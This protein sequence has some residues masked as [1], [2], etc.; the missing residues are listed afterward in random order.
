[1]SAAGAELRYPR[2]GVAG[3]LGRVAGR[4]T[5]L[6]RALLASRL[7]VL[8][9]GIAGALTVPRRLDWQ[10]FDPTHLTMRLGA[11]GNVLAAPAIRWDSVHYLAIAQHGYTRP[12]EAVFFPLYPLLI[13]VLGL[14]VGSDA[15][16]GVVISV[17]SSAAAFTML[18][19]LTELELGRRAADGAVLLL[20]FAP[21]SF[22]FT[23]VYTESLFL[24]LSLGSFYAA[25]RERWR[26]AAVLA[27]M[28]AVTR[29]TGVVL[30]IPLAIMRLRQTRRFE[31]GLAWVLL[32]PA[33]LAGYLAF[34]A[35]KGFGALAPVTEQTGA[36]H[37]HLL[38]GPIDTIVLAVRWAF[39]GVQSLATVAPYQPSLSGPF[40][41]GAENIM[42]LAVLA[43]GVAALVVA[44]RRLPLAYGAYAATALLVCISSP[45]AGLPLHSL[46]RYALTIFPLWM[47]AGAWMAKHRLARAV[48]L[49]G[50]ALLAFFTF[51]FA[52]WAFVA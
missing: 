3:R 36:T 28:A 1:M 19:R 7:I 45:V 49:V 41:G 6:V 16:A 18:H 2:S 12:G 22:F 32:A 40:S 31:R 33:A 38:T 9:A 50:A 52:T 11:L 27:A 17:A 35:A 25:R 29:V 51:Q 37:Q 8:A 21:L 14:L 42:L 43:I 20:A 44:F 15:V 24:A 39:A 13:H 47:A 30:V 46:D 10:A 5:L 26:L 34:T 48:V 4:S 23:A